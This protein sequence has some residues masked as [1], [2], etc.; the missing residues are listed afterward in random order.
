MFE[1]IGIAVVCWIGFVFAKG[2]FK[3]FSTVRGREYGVE[4]RR[5]A[6]K[7]L[8]VPGSYY[9]HIVANSIEGIKSSAIYLRDNVEVY[10]K[11]SWPRLIALVIYGEFHKD[12]EIWGWEE[13]NDNVLRKFEMLGITELSVWQELERD[14]VVVLKDAA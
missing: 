2:L 10:R 12:C 7:E 8:G 3:A 9:N 14:P 5:I 1:F 6:T 4:A 13:D 11:T